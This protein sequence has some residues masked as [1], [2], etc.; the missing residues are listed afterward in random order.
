MSHLTPASPSAH[1]PHQGRTMLNHAMQGVR[2]LI[3][4]NK[5][6]HNTADANPF[7]KASTRQTTSSMNSPATPSNSTHSSNDAS[8][9]A[10]KAYQAHSNSAGRNCHKPKAKPSPSDYSPTT[11]TSRKSRSPTAKH[12]SSR[13][14]IPKWTCRIWN[15]DSYSSKKK[16]SPCQTVHDSDTRQTARRRWC[17]RRKAVS[18]DAC[19]VAA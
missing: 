13:A 6:P 3:N 18:W 17:A 15:H 1:H 12:A 9:K 5:H 14:P 19:P 4:H 16:P 11:T 7:G 10:S 2:Q 8:S